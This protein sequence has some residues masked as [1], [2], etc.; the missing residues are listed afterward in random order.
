MNDK[1]LAKVAKIPIAKAGFDAL[2][3]TA[4]MLVQM[5]PDG[6]WEN[7][8]PGNMDEDRLKAIVQYLVNSEAVSAAQS[9][10]DQCASKSQKE[11]GQSNYVPIIMM[12]IYPAEQCPFDLEC[13]NQKMKEIEEQKPTKK[14]TTKVQEKDP[15]KDKSMKTVKK[16]QFVMQRLTDFD[17]MSQW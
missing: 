10:C 11:G 2:G 12:P 3:M 1:Y 6:K 17:L 16:K 7:S 8:T 14:V 15:G 9:Y 4:P 5:N 13:G